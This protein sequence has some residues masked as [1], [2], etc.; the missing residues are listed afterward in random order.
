[1][2]IEFNVSLNGK[3][4]FATHERSCTNSSKADELKK[5]LLRKFPESAG[6]KVSASIN[7][8]RS[9]GLD[10]S[11]DIAWEINRVLTEL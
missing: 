7:P 6:Y 5:V 2:Y 4:F 3:H 1:M 10:L 8:Q 9:Y 11:K